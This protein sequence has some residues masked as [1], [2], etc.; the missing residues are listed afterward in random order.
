MIDWLNPWLLGA[1]ATIAIPILVHLVARQPSTGS[2]FPSLMFLR[3]M[4]VQTRQPKT[5]RDRLLLLMR[6]LAI[7]LLSIAF[8]GPYCN[9]P[10]SDASSDVLARATV[11]LMDRSYSMSALDRWQHAQDAVG[12]ICDAD[13]ER[14]VSL[15]VFDQVASI[16]SQ[17]T[18]NCAELEQRLRALNPGTRSTR[19][20]RGFRAATDVL[21]DIE[22]NAR[23]LVVI[24]DLQQTETAF[25]PELPSDIELEVVALPLDTP[26]NAGIATVKTEATGN[27]TSLIA[28]VQVINTGQ[29]PLAATLRATLDGND[30]YSQSIALA[31]GQNRQIPIELP[32]R[33]S[34]PREL[35]MSLSSDDI[36][37]DNQ[38]FAVLHPEATL[39]ALVIEP[40]PA[41]Q[42]Q[43]AH[44]VAA[45]RLMR[46]PNI[47]YSLQSSE[48]LA[49]T[50]FDS[51]DL[52]IINDADLQPNAT[53][54]LV[55]WVKRGGRLLVFAGPT[56]SEAAL[57]TLL[58]T[59]P[60]DV[61]T[62]ALGARIDPLA[63]QPTLDQPL[64]LG[65]PSLYRATRIH[66]LW[67]L[68]ESADTRA[69]I[70]LASQTPLAL[71]RRLDAGR[72][73]V[74]ATS[75]DPVWNSLAA[76]PGFVPLV[77][78]LVHQL[79]PRPHPPLHY[80]AGEV[81][82]LAPHAQTSVAWRRHLDDERAVQVEFP[83]G[84]TRVN[85]VRLPG[86]QGVF[87]TD[88]AGVYEVHGAGIDAPLRIA[89]NA[90]RVESH[91]ARW[92]PQEFEASIMRTASIGSTIEGAE[93]GSPTSEDPPRPTRWEWLLAAAAFALL[94][95][96][97][98]YARRRMTRPRSGERLANASVT[99]RTA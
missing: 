24:S 69:L 4:R 67:A 65:S 79:A 7:A 39:R 82:A 86:G 58:G 22:A 21:R 56:T 45:L 85:D 5:L 6:M 76:E 38:F 3:R 18:H 19:F 46:Y 43:S 12:A 10:S 87:Q 66:S 13:P 2:A 68:R 28:D 25:V 71:G 95:L 34:R 57:A 8:A 70:R 74:V 78:A 16:A 54:R 31:A 14:V 11:M 84:Q 61:L 26:T 35:V 33:S 48:R 83:D 44:L 63:G 15:V 92:E 50:D 75:S 89:V 96:E 93:S 37:A 20:D 30:I 62:P 64:D 9:K 88:T 73:A 17:P 55:E 59:P 40:R 72:L 36:A 53:A 52:V 42:F 99:P 98:F 90:P 60:T 47:T 97:V 81:V 41:R 51:L 23:R 1:M 91:L 27:D 80:T 77:R 32:P 49:S 94:V 29:G